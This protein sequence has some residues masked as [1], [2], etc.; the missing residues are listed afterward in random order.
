MEERRAQM[1]HM[2]NQIDYS[3]S[4]IAEREE[5][6]KEIEATMY[7]PYLCQITVITSV[8]V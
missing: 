2:D 6:I 5:A 3:S 4:L 7:V 8:N 1:E